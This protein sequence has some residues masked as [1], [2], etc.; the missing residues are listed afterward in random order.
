VSLVLTSL[1][2]AGGVLLG[3]FIAK[4]APPRGDEPAP[5]DKAEKK[6]QE[7]M[8]MRE[9]EIS[10]DAFPVQLGDVIVRPAQG[11]AWLAGALVFSEDAPVAAVFVAPDAGGDRAILVRPNPAPSIAWLEPVR[12]GTI[13]SGPEPPT[14]IEHEGTRFERLRRLPLRVSRLGSGA[15]DVGDRVIFAEYATAGIE[16]LL[17]LVSGGHARAWRGAVLDEGTYDVL[18]GGKSTL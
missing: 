3:R 17:V 11:E 1:L 10:L 14:S 12:P 15:P 9:P 18:P 8:P 7:T 16:R 6:E 5:A 2:V 13:E 4:S